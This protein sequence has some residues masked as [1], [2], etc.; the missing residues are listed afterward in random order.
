MDAEELVRQLVYRIEHSMLP[1]HRY[2]SPYDACYRL[3]HGLG[4]T[5]PEQCDC[6]LDALLAQ[7]RAFTSDL[8]SNIP[9]HFYQE[10]PPV[11]PL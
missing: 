2:G 3:Q 11:Q 8:R 6:G 5:R 1:L 7:A 4:F 10:P 9:A